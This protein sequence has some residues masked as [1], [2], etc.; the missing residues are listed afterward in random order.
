K[1]ELQDKKRHPTIEDNVTIYAN[2]T[3]LGGKTVIGEGC[4]IGG[5]TWVMQSVPPHTMVSQ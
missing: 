5:N 3:I 1:K 2:A 4:T